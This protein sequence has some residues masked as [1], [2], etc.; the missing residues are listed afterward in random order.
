M[1]VALAQTIHSDDVVIDEAR[2]SIGAISLGELEWFRY[3]IELDNMCQQI[4]DGDV[5]L[6]PSRSANPGDLA[7]HRTY[8]N[9][10]LRIV[11]ARIF[12][13]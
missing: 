11:L 7:F 12:H 2:L 8:Q 5:D 13:E 4:K 9:W 1:L 10:S 6:L 3:L